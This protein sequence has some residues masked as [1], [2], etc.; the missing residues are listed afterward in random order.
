MLGNFVL[1]LPLAL[2]IKVVQVIFT[3]SGLI[4]RRSFDVGEQVSEDYYNTPGFLAYVAVNNSQEIIG[5]LIMFSK[6]L[7]RDEVIMF[8]LRFTQSLL[9]DMKVTPIENE[10]NQQLYS[11]HVNIYKL[12]NRK[13]IIFIN[14]L[15]RLCVII[16]GIRSSQVKMLKD[17]FVSTLNEYLLSEGI[18]QN[19]IDAY[20]NDGADMIISKTNSRSVLGTMKEI[21]MYS[22]DTHLDFEDHIGRMKWLNKLIYKPIDYNK[23]KDVFKEAI[24]QILPLKMRE[25]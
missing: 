21:T 22:A 20:I 9:K 17:K 23:P 14:D 12:N 4:L 11:W 16:D 19:V 10:D 5:A 7:E 25:H 8:V 18:N 13:H 15:S 6:G 2:F 3:M 24:N 1:I